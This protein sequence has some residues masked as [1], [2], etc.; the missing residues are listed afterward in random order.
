MSHKPTAPGV[1]THPRRHYEIVV[2]GPVGPT[3]LQAFPALTAQR[4]SD[5]TVLSGPLA[6]RSA[7]YGVLYQL[8]ALGMELLEVRS[9]VSPNDGH[10]KSH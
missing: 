9:S 4:R 2:R 8:E 5:D 6:D 10:A 3:L 1:G 7:L